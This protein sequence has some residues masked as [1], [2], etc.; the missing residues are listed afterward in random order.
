MKTVTLV[1]EESEAA[2]VETGGV[3]S[4]ESVGHPPIAKGDV[5]D[6]LMG[7]D[8]RGGAGAREEDVPLHEQPLRVAGLLEN[9]LR[10]TK[11]ESP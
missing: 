6:I 3:A 10:D 9:Y 1:L 8:R 7:R 4:A 2:A 5:D 11:V